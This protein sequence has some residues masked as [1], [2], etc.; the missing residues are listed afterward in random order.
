[1]T[2]PPLSQ[3]GP[4]LPAR[5]AA[6]PSQEEGPEDTFEPRE[7]AVTAAGTAVAGVIS[8]P[9]L[10]ETAP[11]NAE[12]REQIRGML[13]PGDVLARNRDGYPGWNLYESLQFGS[14]DWQH[15]GLYLGDG[16]VCE[17]SPPDGVRLARVEDFLKASHIG[18]FRPEY[19][20]RAARDRALDHA[21]SL[22]GRP[23]DYFFDSRDAEAVY[24]SELILEALDHGPGRPAGVPVRT[25]LGVPK[26][27]PDA[28]LSS[29][30]IRR[31]WSNGQT[32]ESHL[33]SHWPGLSVLAG[34]TVAGAAGAA[35][36]GGSLG[37]GLAL[38]VAA[39]LAIN[40]MASKF[41]R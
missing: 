35:T 1:M 32:E 28:L 22:V 16:Q 37:A 27:G 20:G 10:S 14:S 23:Y 36:L 6:P 15:V 38:G 25:L 18:V 26:V 33:R 5:P 41:G 31:I 40:F 29:P 17:A 7:A 39:G 34:A 24:C 13:Q 9:L 21:R 11:L 4:S 30:G 12:T 19:G 8:L 2:V 3:P